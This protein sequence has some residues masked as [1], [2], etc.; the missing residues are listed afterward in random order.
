MPRALRVCPTPR[1]ANTT[2]QGR[3][4][5]CRTQA[6]HTRGTARQRGYDQRH[7]TGFRP[8]VLRRDPLCVCA[9]QT[10]GHGPRCLAPS[11]VADHHPYSRRELVAMGMD[12][13]DPAHGRGI[14]EGCHNKH[15]SYAQP[16]GWNAAQ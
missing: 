8:A 4:A 2:T 7:E 12:P 16:G 9:D 10:H 15:T 14:C 6:E 13:Y 11:R 5:T 1:C 3:C